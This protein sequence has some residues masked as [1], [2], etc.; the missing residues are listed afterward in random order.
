MFSMYSNVI[1]SDVL[2]VNRVNVAEEKSERVI[3]YKVCSYLSVYSRFPCDL[4]ST[5]PGV[6]RERNR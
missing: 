3:W 4:A 6:V 1:S 5:G 2:S